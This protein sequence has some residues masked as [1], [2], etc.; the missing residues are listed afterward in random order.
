MGTH[1]RHLAIAQAVL[2][3]ALLGSL[4]LA[5]LSDLPLARAAQPSD[6]ALKEQADALMKN[7]EE[8]VAHGGMGDA[9]AIVHHCGEASRHAEALLAQITPSDPRRSQASVSLNEVILQCKRVSEI[10]PHA[11]PGLLLNPAIKARSA[12]RESVKSLGLNPKS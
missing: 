12:A 5:I 11:D 7:A 4:N 6:A 9:K 2:L 3:S 1:T 10:G 8:M